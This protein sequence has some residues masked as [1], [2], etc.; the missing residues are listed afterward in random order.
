ML[1]YTAEAIYHGPDGLA[2]DDE[3]RPAPA[4]TSTCTS[5]NVFGLDGTGLIL[6][7][8][9]FDRMLFAEQLKDVKKQ[10]D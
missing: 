5:I 1:H 7:R 6:E 8:C 10:N 3:E 2:V 4:P 9:Y